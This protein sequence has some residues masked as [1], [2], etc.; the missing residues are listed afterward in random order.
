MDVAVRAQRAAESL[1]K[2]VL[3]LSFTDWS[4]VRVTAELTRRV[5]EWGVDHGWRVR[6]EVPSIA[7]LP[8]AHPDRPG[9]LD[10][11][12]ERLDGPPIAV[13]IDRTD[14][15]WSARKLLCEAD[16]GAVAVWVRWADAK[17][18]IVPP[19]IGVV[20]VPTTVSRIGGR[21]LY[22]RAASQYPPTDASNEATERQGAIVRPAMETA[23]ARGEARLCRASTRKGHPC[24][25]NAR[26][27]G[28]CHVH[29]PE[30]Q[31]GAVKKNGQRCTNATG[32]GRCAKHR[33]GPAFED[34]ATLL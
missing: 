25:I 4:A 31:C 29:D 23:G 18:W 12:C 16:A 10:V 5:V 27:S 21:R 9:Y 6:R 22:S 24:P 13:E 20:R 2:Y 28:L 34:A 8:G 19:S 1:A 32:G 15:Q 14:K 26:P 30:V 7:G 11:V 17:T 33:N 3:P